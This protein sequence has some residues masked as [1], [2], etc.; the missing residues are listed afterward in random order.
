[1]SKAKLIFYS[2]VAVAVVVVGL[3]L[4]RWVRGLPVFELL[5]EEKQMER[6]ATI[7]RSVSNTHRWVFLTVEDEEVVVREHRFGNVAKIY[8]TYYELG[9]ELD[10]SLQWVDVREQDGTRV[11]SLHLPPVK[12]LNP[13]DGF[14]A[15][16]VINVYGD[17][18]DDEQ[19]GMMEE[20]ERKSRARALSEA[21]RKQ[22]ARNA[23]EHFTNLFMTLGCDSV[24]IEWRKR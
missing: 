19:R 12:I 2:V 15:T 3:C 4:Y 8:P 13:A 23:S 18:D 7:L 24:T 1:M 9:I 17:A 10:D 20:A 22:A 5:R 16:K 6:T 21:N 14:D 11:A